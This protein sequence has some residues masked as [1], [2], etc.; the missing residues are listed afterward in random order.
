[1]LRTISSLNGHTIRATD[2]ELGH[3]KK[4]YLDEDQWTVRYLVVETGAWLFKRAVL[5]SPYSI[6]TIDDIDEAIDVSLT[7]EQIKNAPEVDPKTRLSRNAESEYSRYYGYDTYWTG[8]NV[9]GTNPYPIMRSASAEGLPPAAGFPANDTLESDAADNGSGFYLRDSDELQR[10]DI[11]GSD[12]DIGHV[13]DFIFDDESW[14]VHYL[15]VDTRNWWPGGKKVLIAIH[16]IDNINWLDAK[17]RVNLTREQIKNSPEYDPNVAV[18]RNYETN[19][20]N[21]YDRKAYWD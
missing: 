15:I 10:Y 17:V 20:H 12:G 9:W 18:D 11:E 3:I 6:K 14:R 8:P 21:Y 4:L 19:L 13:E 1:M 7:R 16:W 2:G 5:L